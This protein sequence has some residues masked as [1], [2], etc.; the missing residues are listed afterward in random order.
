MFAKMFAIA[1]AGIILVPVLA[2]LFTLL[3][4]VGP[5][6]FIL[7]ILVGSFLLSLKFG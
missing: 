2:L 4:N 6:N 5:L 7:V 1:G 3:S